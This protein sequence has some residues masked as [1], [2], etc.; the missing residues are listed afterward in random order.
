MYLYL[1]SKQMALDTSHDILEVGNGDE[2]GTI[3]VKPP[4]GFY[5]ILLVEIVQ[6][7]AKL[8]VAYTTFLVLTEVKLRKTAFHVE[9]NALV[10]FGFF[11]NFHKFI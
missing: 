6:E 10:K 2:A 3:P 8:A 5:R 11:H 1:L 9:R 7:L 4:E